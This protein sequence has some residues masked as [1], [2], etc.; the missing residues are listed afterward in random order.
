MKKEEN[1]MSEL[2][3]NQ[4]IIKMVG[5]MKKDYQRFWQASSK[6]EPLS[7]FAQDQL[8]NFHESIEIHT[9]KKYIKIVRNDGQSMVWGFIVNTDNDKQFKRGDILKP[10]G[11]AA[12]ARN[13]ARG[14]VF[15][16]LSWVQW[17][18]PAYL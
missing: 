18:G 14:N 15:K 9:G 4:A 3:M 1:R 12:P 7:D 13:K 8:D 17:T 11:W 2:T 5:V 6:G 10:A 16:D